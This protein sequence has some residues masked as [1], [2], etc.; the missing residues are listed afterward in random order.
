M[1][2]FKVN[3]DVKNDVIN[4]EDISLRACYTYLPL[5]NVKR[6]IFAEPLEC[7]R[8]GFWYMNTISLIGI[9]TDIKDN[10]GIVTVT[11]ASITFFYPEY[12]KQNLRYKNDLMS[13]EFTDLKSSLFV[14]AIKLNK[15]SPI[16]DTFFIKDVSYIADNGIIFKGN[17]KLYGLIF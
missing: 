7:L 11:Q 5:T 16:L 9:F 12:K 3:K 10:T 15:Y 14:D 1:L 4:I 6:E 2:K 17:D 13:I 8:N